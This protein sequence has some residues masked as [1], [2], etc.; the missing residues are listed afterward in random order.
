MR[1]ECETEKAIDLSLEEA[2]LWSDI[3]RVTI[4]ALPLSFTRYTLTTKKILITTGFL[5]KREEEIRLYRIKDISWSQTIFQR[6]FGVGSLHITSSDS[7]LPNLDIEQIKDS[8]EIKNLISSAVESSRVK[9][10]VRA[11]EFLGAGE[12]IEDGGLLS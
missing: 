6:I 1:K 11:S 2:E 4:L 9:A 7:T 10:G 3:K 5:T 8:K 12:D